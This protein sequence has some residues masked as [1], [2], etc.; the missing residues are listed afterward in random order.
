MSTIK[1]LKAQ[2]LEHKKATKE[3]QEE[4]LLEAERN[5]AKAESDCNNNLVTLNPY[6]NTDSHGYF[7]CKNSLETINGTI[8]G[9][10]PQEMQDYGSMLLEASSKRLMST[11]VAH[12]TI[13]STLS[14]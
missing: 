2:R 6:H 5:K 13:G 12:A 3:R 7:T 9:P 8:T 14:G 11:N 4:E 10:R 1:R